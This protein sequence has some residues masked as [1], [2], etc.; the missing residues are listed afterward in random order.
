MNMK[1]RNTIKLGILAVST[2][3]AITACGFRVGHS[4][5]I[6]SSN[7]PIGSSINNESSE[8]NNSSKMDQSSETPVSSSSINEQSSTQ[9]IS[10]SEAPISSSEAPSSSEEP[11]VLE[12]IDAINNV[13]EYELG[14][15]LNLTVTAYYSDGSF[16]V[17]NEYEIAGFDNQVSGN[18]VVSITFAGKTTTVEVYVKPKPIP[19]NAF[20]SDKLAE[21]LEE[22]SILLDIPSPVGYEAWNDSTDI[23]NEKMPCFIASTVDSGTLGS[24]SIQD[25][26]FATLSEDTSWSIASDSTGY[27]AIKEN[28]KVEFSTSQ[29]IFSF[30]VHVLDLDPSSSAN[31]PSEQLQEFLTANGLLTLVPDA[32]SEHRWYYETGEDASLGSYFYVTSNDEGVSGS[33]AIED[34]YKATLSIDE[35]TIDGENYSQEGYYAIKDDVKLNFYT[36]DGHFVLIV[37]EY[38]NPYLPIVDQFGKWELVND[39]SSLNEGDHIVIADYRYKVIAGPSSSNGNYL[40]PISNV[41]ITEDGIWNL[42]ENTTQFVLSKSGTYWRLNTENS[43]LGASGERKIGFNKASNEWSI[44]IS[45]GNASITNKTENYGT[46]GYYSSVN[47]FTTYKSGFNDTKVL[48]QIYRFVELVPIYPTALSISAE[49]NEI[50]VGKTTQLSVGY[51]PE[52]TNH[53]GVT[54]SSSNTNIATVSDL[55][56]VKGVS[57]GV[58]TITASARGENDTLITA[59]INI[60]VTRALV[61]EWTLMLYICGADL[62]SANGLASMDIDEILNVNG[63]PDDVNIIME[64]GGATGWTNSKISAT[65]LGRYHVENKQI[66]QDASLSNASMGKTTTFTSFMN[67]G[68]ENYPASK[69]G[70]VFWNHGGALDG[71]CYD[72]NYSDDSLLNSEVK[73]ALT[74]VFA[75]QGLTDKLE[76]VG[77]DACLMQ[78]QDVAD[79]NS[80]FFN[81]M[82]G[83]EEAEAGYGWAYEGWI[84]DLYAKKSTENILKAIV[85]SFYNYYNSVYGRSYNDQ[86]LSVLKLSEMETYR[87]AWETMA[88]TIKS[89]AKANLSAFKG[90]LKTCKGY[91][92]QEMS[93]SEYVE[94]IQAGYPSEWFE[95]VGS[96]YILHGYWFYGTFDAYDF[97]N[98]LESNSSYS[99]YANQINAVKTAFSSLVIY[100]KAGQAAG[101]SNGLALVSKM[102]YDYKQSETNFTTWRSIFY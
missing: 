35:W 87:T 51:I 78:V 57:E 15:S 3:L 52:E 18:Q 91:A 1:N 67:W 7:N 62:E 37:S 22:Q 63:Q 6:A 65:K 43:K 2:L 8:T 24:D 59:N 48:P 70:L 5:K 74:S 99:S 75:T 84:D 71:V 32:T 26:Y 79:F 23:D 93:Y 16:E 29:G 76:F 88:S 101:N 83:S 45:D 97:L 50:G 92:D 53:K 72:E 42:P 80:Q 44:S 21:F 12:R 11:V 36:A 34:T 25:T 66:V 17:L 54:W 73:S 27:S 31:F 64:T 33:N 41:E 98:K 4:S 20:P 94:Y 46:I 90:I 56:V 19:V 9:I 85:D 68:L 58:A 89:T 38:V 60:S 30:F 86:T 95:H 10:S 13:E 47:I 39:A 82:V 49:E 55:G 77:Y 100:N 69:T 14:D 81:Y 96:S 40:T 28:V 61:D 102:Y